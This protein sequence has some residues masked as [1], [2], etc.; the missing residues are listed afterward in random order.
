MRRIAS[1]SLCLVGLLLAWS[2]GCG[3]VRSERGD[4]AT[5]DRL[6]STTAAEGPRGYAGALT[7]LDGQLEQ[8]RLLAEQRGGWADHELVAQLAI[9]R[10]RLTGSIDDWVTADR[11]LDAAFALAPEGGG[12]LLTRLELDL[13][14][15]RL[16]AAEARIAQVEAAP[17]RTNA[18]ELRL[19][20]ARGDLEAQH[21]RLDRA[22]L[23]F[24]RAEQLGASATVLAGRRALLAG[25]REQPERARSSLAQARAHARADQAIAWLL[26]QE[27][28]VEWRRDRPQAALVRYEAAEDAFPGW[29]LVTEHRAEALAALGR[30]D[31]AESLYRQVV[32]QTG[33]PELM[34][35]LAQLLRRSGREDEAREWVAKARAEHERRL[36]LLPRAAGAHA[37]DHLLRHA[38]DQPLT[39][40][41]AR[42]LG[43]AR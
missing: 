43:R 37:L 41:L 32:E 4:A 29:W 18:I 10:A 14:L 12:P 21:G 16:D 27:G 22:R 3:L 7:K 23:D 13:S 5:A 19:A 26:L 15:H 34:D 11:A 42:D 35:A 36:T 40:Q 17:L 25:R 9:R 6:A 8:A 24:E 20:L 30:R 39:R 31:E 38:P 28:L 2:C 33:H 1:P